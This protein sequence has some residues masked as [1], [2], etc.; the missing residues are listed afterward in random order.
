MWREMGTECGALSPACSDV[1]RASAGPSGCGWSPRDAWRTWSKGD[2]LGL[3]DAQLQPHLSSFV[4]RVTEFPGFP[5]EVAPP[6]S[7]H[8]GRGGEGKGLGLHMGCPSF[9]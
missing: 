9:P 8:R 2:R 1:A 3:S 6:H 7:G 4:F 5:H